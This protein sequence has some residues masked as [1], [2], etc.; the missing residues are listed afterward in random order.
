MAS[1]LKSDG[2]KPTIGPSGL[3]EFNLDDFAGH[4]RELL[5][6][7]QARARAILNQAEKDAQQLRQQAQRDGKRDGLAEARKTVAQEVEQQVQSEVQQQLGLLKEAVD[8]LA[9]QQAQWLQEFAG[10]LQALAIGV[11]EAILRERLEKEPAILLRWAE[12]ALTHCRS[13]RELVIAVHPETLVS[14]GESLEALLRASGAPEN[15]RIEPDESIERHGAVIRQPG[16]RVD[17][18]LTSQLETLRPLL[19]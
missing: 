9:N 1:I 19:E 17:A 6:K 14:L 2:A 4:Q 8:Q 16:G 10:T 13:A 7:T 18:Q 5:E 3:A 15:A 11:A 12:E